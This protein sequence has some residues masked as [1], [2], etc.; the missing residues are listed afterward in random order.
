MVADMKDIK[1]HIKERMV[2]VCSK[3]SKEFGE[4]LA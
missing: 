2:G 4:R 3:V 1:T